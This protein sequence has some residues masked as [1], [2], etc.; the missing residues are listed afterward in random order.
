MKIG[1]A[2]VSTSGQTLDRQTDQLKAHGCDRIFE[3]KM[4]GSRKDRPELDK[5]FGMLR[6]GD[7][8]V[9]ASL[10][11]LGRSMRHLMEMVD[12]LKTEGVELVSLKETIDTST[13]A[14]KLL[15]HM[16]AA[17]AEFERTLL[18]ERVREGLDAAKKRGR[19]GGRRHRLPKADR[20]DMIMDFAIRGLSA[21]EASAKRGMK[22]ASLF[23]MAQ[24]MKASGEWAELMAGLPPG[25]AV[26]GGRGCPPVVEKEEVAS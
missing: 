15:F 4:S 3:E 11:R 7:S 24:R 19:V 8:L 20:V 25:V 21:R 17:L 10:D 5:I 14:G 23:R 6:S 1:Y 16:L 13:S 9:V 2:R 12:L 22:Q 18:T 26:K